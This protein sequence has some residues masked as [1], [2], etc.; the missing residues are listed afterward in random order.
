MEQKTR[1]LIIR[2]QHTGKLGWYG[3]ATF[4]LTRL[5]AGLLFISRL[6]TLGLAGAVLIGSASAQNPAATASGEQKAK[7]E[8]QIRSTYLL[9]SDDQLEI[10]GPELT[11]LSNKPVRID[12]EGDIQVPLAGTV[13]VAGMTVQ[14]TEQELDKVLSKY[15]RQPQVVVNVAEVRSQP[16]SVLGAVN[17]PGVHQVQ[18]HKTVLE[19]LAMAGGIRQDAGYSIRIT[20]QLEWGCIP[21]PGAQLDASGKYS[22]AEVN[23]RKIMDAK[24]PEENI[25]I[26]P[27]DVISVPKAEMV[28]VIGEVHRSGGFVLGEHQSISVLQA[29]SLAE[30]LNTGADPRH[31]KILRLKPEAD[32]REELRVDVKDA[33]NGKKPDFPLQGEDILFIPGS[34][35]KKAALRGL[36]AAIQT[37]TGLAI[38]RVP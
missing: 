26:F 31:A 30:G 9:G 2:K 3:L 15:I 21:L 19:M 6:L 16:V 22:V 37:G 35:G 20:R 12:G 25:Q 27:H 5:A 17:S 18:G 33:L 4:K 1:T 34:T 24:T 14:Q 29:L 23:L 38:W 36:E 8:N 11:D 7:C 28:Y 10:T 13:H 32:Q